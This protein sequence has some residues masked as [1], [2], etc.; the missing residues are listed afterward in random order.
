MSPPGEFGPLDDKIRVEAADWFA[1]MRGPDAEASRHQF[2][3]WYAIPAHAQAYEQMVGRWDQS[4][5][6]GASPTGQSRRLERASLVAR[7]PV[8]SAAAAL[9]GVVGCAAL[10]Y[11]EN[12]T[13]GTGR[14]TAATQAPERY[15]SDAVVREI[16]LRDGSRV[17]LDRAS[18][19]F[20]SS[21]PGQ[22]LLERGRA[23]F[24]PLPEAGR[25][26]VV[27]AGAAEIAS[28]G[29]RFDAA[30]DG[31]V[32]VVYALDG[33]VVV[34]RR[35]A[36]ARLVLAGQQLIV[37]ARGPMSAAK[38]APLGAGD[39]LPVMIVLDHTSLADAALQV[40][41]GA[42]TRLLFVDDASALQITGSFRRGDIEGL[43]RAAQA[44]FHLKRG[45]DG[46]GNI[47]LA[48]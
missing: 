42:R 12:R 40:G 5:F 48:R 45:R 46:A 34:R 43:A 47:V 4:V 22:A 15:R 14:E 21:S 17:T 32:A 29:S 33:T 3:A 26:F 8:F 9:I 38:P 6:T 31:G 23:R 7:H 25:P 36:P 35:A 18:L 27:H 1:R 28:D 30:Y 19:I 2:D 39:W 20:V 13:T 24:E 10:L 16:S 11:V 37:P 44:M 41:R